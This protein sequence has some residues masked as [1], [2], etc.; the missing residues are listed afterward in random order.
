MGYPV[1]VRPTQERARWSPLTEPRESG[2]PAFSGYTGA[3]Q[4]EWCKEI[5][6]CNVVLEGRWK[7]SVRRA[8]ERRGAAVDHNSDNNADDR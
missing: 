2:V 8:W 7:R 5:C 3:V 1:P 6:D 4:P